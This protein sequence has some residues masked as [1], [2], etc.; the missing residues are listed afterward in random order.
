M[1]EALQREL[2]ASQQQ[3]TRLRE[4]AALQLARLE[5]RNRDLEDQLYVGELKWA[6]IAATEV[7]SGPAED[8]ETD[9]P[10]ASIV[11]ASAGDTARLLQDQLEVERGKVRRLEA[12]LAAASVVQS[13]RIAEGLQA[14]Q[15]ME[16]DTSRG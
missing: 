10:R 13:E 2:A 1:L 12:E 4:E 6:S 16:D 15:G 14:E 5:A 8:I 11:P 7:G 3:Q 9:T